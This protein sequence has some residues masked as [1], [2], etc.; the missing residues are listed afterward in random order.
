VQRIGN[1]REVGDELP[2]E[3]DA[4]RKAFEFNSAGEG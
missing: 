1:I 2:V 4:T 3:V